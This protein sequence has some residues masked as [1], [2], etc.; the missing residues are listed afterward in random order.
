M[1][2]VSIIIRLDDELSLFV[3][4]SGIWKSDMTI[5]HHIAEKD[6]SMAN[7]SVSK[8][9]RGSALILVQFVRPR[10]IFMAVAEATW[11]SHLVRSII[12]VLSVMAVIEYLESTHTELVQAHD[13]VRWWLFT[14]GI[15]SA[16]SAYSAI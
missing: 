10:I 12:G 6:I 15:Y 8:G 11:N 13:A 1:D 16:L 3:G 2:R 5:I 14:N 4:M 9:T 7:I